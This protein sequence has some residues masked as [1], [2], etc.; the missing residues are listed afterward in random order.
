MTPVPPARSKSVL[1]C[2]VRGCGAPLEPEGRGVRCARG[3]A[4]DRA[5]SGYLNLLQPQDRRSKR[6]G[7]PPEAVAA[8]R[9][10]LETGAEALILEGVIALVGTLGLGYAP[11]VL[12]VGCGEGTY[13]AAIAGRLSADG[14]GVDISVPA[15]EM[16]ARRAPGHVWVV[17]NAD[18]LLPFATGA[19]DFVASITARRNASE[20]RRV[21]APTGRLLVAVPGSDDLAELREAVLGHAGSRSRQS[22]VAAE[23]EGRFDL[24]SATTV[25]HRARLGPDAARDALAATY[26]VGRARRTARA[27]LLGELEVTLSRDLMLFRPR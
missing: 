18:R 16:A 11:R 7:D 2:T 20:M 27:A 15:V 6:P 24:E 12:D 19:F 5:K 8:R 25:R 3:H 10:F 9:R 17:A 21:L 26:R 23:L 22:R 1:I 4:F 14:Y 13:L